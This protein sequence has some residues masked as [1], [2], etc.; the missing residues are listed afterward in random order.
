MTYPKT[1]FQLLG[2]Y[3]RIFIRAPKTNKTVS[4][5]NATSM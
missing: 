4:L 1:L 5:V 3:I 2:P